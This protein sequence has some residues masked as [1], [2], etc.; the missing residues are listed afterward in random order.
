MNYCAGILR[1][2]WR[3]C[4]STLRG[5]AT[6]FPPLRAELCPDF[7]S[8]A[9]AVTPQSAAGALKAEH[10]G[11]CPPPQLRL[12]VSLLNTNKHTPSSLLAGGRTECWELIICYRAQPQFPHLISGEV[13]PSPPAGTGGNRA[14]MLLGNWSAGPRRG[15][16]RLQGFLLP[17]LTPPP[18]GEAQSSL[19][20]QWPL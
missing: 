13:S 7:P 5:S 10:Q 20:P 8:I 3:C 1:T 19:A 17:W 6:S 16:R 11:R 12:C 9:C 14:R 18:L 15:R 4:E 2:Y